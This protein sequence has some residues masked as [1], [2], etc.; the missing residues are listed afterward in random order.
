MSN[1]HIQ[2]QSAVELDKNAFNNLSKTDISLRWTL[3]SVPRGF[4]RLRE[5]RFYGKTLYNSFA[6]KGWG[7]SK[8]KLGGGP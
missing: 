4:A 6:V 1:K 8:W 5:N 7:P 2:P 3:L